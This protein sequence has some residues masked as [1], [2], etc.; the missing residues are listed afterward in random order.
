M[1]SPMP[2]R[3]LLTIATLVALIAPA[4]A[5]ASPAQA[6]VVGIA[7]Q[8]AASFDD[9]LL[10]DLPVRHARL[11]V[12]WDAMDY[13]WQRR[14]I[15]VW[16]RKANA[17]D[18]TVVV[19][20]GRSRTRVFRL[21]SVQEYRARVG[22]FMR[23]Y[24]SVREYSPWNEPNLARL[25]ANSDPH[26]IA[27]Y[28]RTLRSLCGA[29]RIMGAD[30]VDSSNLARWMTAYL[31]VFR[32]GRA[33]RLWGLHNYVDVN[34]TSRW[35]TK[36]MLRLAAGQI[37]LTEPGPIISRAKPSKTARS[38]RRLLMRQ[39]RRRSAAATER[40]FTLAAMSPRI[41][42]VYIYHWRAG[43]RSS[44]DSGLLSSNGTPRPSFDVFAHEA[45]AAAGIPDPDDVAP[46][47]APPPAPPPA[48]PPSGLE[49]LVSPS[50][51]S[52]ACTMLARVWLL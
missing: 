3:A 34:S 26:R 6:L 38:D 11:S 12:P 48:S 1:L 47:A 22:T 15:D 36:T 39:G 8:K 35:G 5:V 40:V 21:P 16:I 49:C 33:P 43:A 4:L 29:C 24:R 28:Y 9:K 31:R 44:W 25:P 27:A 20:F 45:R 18:M 17:A 51:A 7:D 13:R 10:T 14:E 52:G 41:S 37:W 23:R 32:P 19:T 46:P 50:C 2:R 42:R 30:L